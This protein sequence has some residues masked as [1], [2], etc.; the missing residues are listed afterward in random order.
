M[1]RVRRALINTH[2]ARTVARE[3]AVNVIL[4]DDNPKVI[5]DEKE[6]YLR[7]QVSYLEG[8]IKAMKKHI[9]EPRDNKKNNGSPPTKKRKRDAEEIDIR[10]KKK[11]QVSMPEP[12]SHRELAVES[13]TKKDEEEF[14]EF[15]KD[16]VDFC[17]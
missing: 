8:V 11:Q 16:F 2:G 5:T 14:D 7:L 12:S 13:I 15:M 3:A 9:I 1:R 17:L 10:E 6:K 4:F